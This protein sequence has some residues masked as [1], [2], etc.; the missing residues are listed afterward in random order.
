MNKKGLLIVDLQSGFKPN[1]Q[2]VERI[3]FSITN[4]NFSSIVMTRFVNLPNSLFRSV[5]NW[6]EDGG[7]LVLDVPDAIILQKNGYGLTQKHVELIRQLGCI[8]WHVSGLET[9]GCFVQTNP[10]KT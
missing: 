8:E 9:D 6:Q 5:L 4:E 1:H 3:R 7:D 2:L 10:I